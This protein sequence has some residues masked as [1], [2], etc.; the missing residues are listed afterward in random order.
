MRGIRTPFR[1]TVVAVLVMCGHGCAGSPGDPAGGVRNGMP[2]AASA[3]PAG[4]ATETDASANAGSGVDQDVER[5]RRAT[6]AFRELD[7]A[8]RAG[9]PDDVPHCLENPPAGGMGH[10]H[11]HPDL[12]DDRIE[13]ERPEILVYERTSGGEYELVGVE[14]AVPLDAWT[15]DS[16]PNV[17]GQDLKR[18]PALGLWYLHVWVW[19]ENPSG[20]FADWNPA[21]T[22]RH[23]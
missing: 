5:V 16:P 6:A 8:V 1:G 20:L 19:R 18:A 22:C 10:H 12:L 7:A 23:A 17:M 2:D 11:I 15:G 13:L 9:Y 4:T 3:A 14:Y 21:V